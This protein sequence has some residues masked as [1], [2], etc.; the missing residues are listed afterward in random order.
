MSQPF[1]DVFDRLVTEVGRA[2]A[3]QTQPVQPAVPVEVEVSGHEDRIRIRLVAGQVA[4]L[5]L[6]PAAMRLSNAELAD[7]LRETFNEALAA[8]Q[9]AVVQAVTEDDTDLGALQHRLRDI[10]RET[11]RSMQRYSD[12]MLAMLRAAK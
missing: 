3:L 5:T 1:D 7:H 4:E 2:E 10:Q 12:Q 6:H 9:S 11:A 8:Y